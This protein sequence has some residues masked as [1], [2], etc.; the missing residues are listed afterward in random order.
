[1]IYNAIVCT[2][3]VATRIKSDLYS[4]GLVIVAGGIDGQSAK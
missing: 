3:F 1:M 4:W 2:S